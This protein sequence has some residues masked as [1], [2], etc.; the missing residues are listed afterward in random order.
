MKKPRRADEMA[1]EAGSTGFCGPLSAARGE[2]NALIERT[3]RGEVPISSSFFPKNHTRL[4][5]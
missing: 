5:T 2:P 1:E 4:S 3:K